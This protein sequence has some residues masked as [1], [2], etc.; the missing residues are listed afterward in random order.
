[1]LSR[2]G[3]EKRYCP[4]LK[5]NDKTLNLFQ[6]PNNFYTVP[7]MTNDKV[8]TWLVHDNLIKERLPGMSWPLICHSVPP[9][10]PS[11]G[12]SL[13]SCWLCPCV[14]QLKWTVCACHCPMIDSCLRPAILWKIGSPILAYYYHWRW[15]T[16]ALLRT[17]AYKRT[18]AAHHRYHLI[19]SSVSLWS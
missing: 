8:I 1:M 16:R 10:D 13:G 18:P 14:V 3:G 5:T 9:L 17:Q 7:K 19:S 12:G 15:S 6:T 2:D 4:L 11:L